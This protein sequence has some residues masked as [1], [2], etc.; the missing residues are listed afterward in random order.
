MLLL[1]VVIAESTGCLLVC[2]KYEFGTCHGMS[3]QEFFV[4]RAVRIHVAFSKCAAI[5][6]FMRVI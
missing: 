3:C 2:L 6:V 1:S 4:G 5:T